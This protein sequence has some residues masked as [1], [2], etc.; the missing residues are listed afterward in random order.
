MYRDLVYS[1]R[2]ALKN[3]KARLRRTEIRWGNEE[4][5]T[6]RHDLECLM[7]YLELQIDE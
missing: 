3:L 4:S 1:Y 5:Y 6:K 2:K 7:I